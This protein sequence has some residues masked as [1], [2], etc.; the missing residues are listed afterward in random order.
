MPWLKLQQK[1]H[2]KNLSKSHQE[3]E[4]ET[5][6]K[7]YDLPQ[8]F[9]GHIYPELCDDYMADYARSHSLSKHG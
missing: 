2:Y 5:V 6:A 9:I 7:I 8:Q 4:L 3:T 1:A